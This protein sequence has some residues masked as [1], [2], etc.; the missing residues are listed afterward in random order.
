MQRTT[1]GRV[2]RIAS[3]AVL[4]VMLL[5]ILAFSRQAQRQSTATPPTE[6]L[7]VVAG[8]RTD[9][10]TLLDLARQ[11]SASLALPAAPHELATIQN[12]LYVTLT[13]ADLLAEIDPHAPG[14]LRLLSLDG[15]PHGLAASPSGPVLYI[16]LGDANALV[17]LDAASLREL[18]RWPTGQTPHAV[19]IAQ[20]IP[21]LAAA[22]ADR[23]ETV[24]PTGGTSAPAGRL[25]ETIA[26]LPDAVVA[27]SYLDGNLHIYHPVTLQPNATL[28]LGGGPVRVIPLDHHTVAVALQQA[29]RVA[30]VDLAAAK[31]VRLL[32]VPARPDGLCLSPS[33]A[34][35]AVAS[36]GDSSV[37]VFQTSHWRIA[38]R[39]Q[40]PQ[41]PGACLWLPG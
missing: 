6:G 20:G 33:G 37:T 14:L 19:A 11:T 5:A 13:R 18:D 17:A 8:L 25:P 4:P 39:L 40:V 26:A 7:L 36:N 38:A 30:I 29:D 27:A 22:R 1:L 2:N 41:G 10:L 35:L 15:R 24:R 3:L 34:Y 28:H 16:T 9:Q 23:V 31:I 32:D 21:H 12:R